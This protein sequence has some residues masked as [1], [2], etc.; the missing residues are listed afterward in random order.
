MSVTVVNTIPSPRPVDSGAQGLAL[1][2]PPG[3]G[4]DREALER[5]FNF[6]KFPKLKEVNFSLWV[7][8]VGGGI[9]WIP[10]VLSTLSPI[11]SPHLSSLQIGF[12]SSPP[13][14]LPEISE[15]M[16]N[17]LQRIADQVARIEREFEGAVNSTV[18]RDPN[19]ES[20]LKI[21]FPV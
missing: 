7:S 11:T 6:S 20:V 16:S 14:L 2:P 10:M 21:R 17:D 3:I 18:I 15:D 4:P 1:M 19:F 9:P 12:F 13:N 8:R 5:S